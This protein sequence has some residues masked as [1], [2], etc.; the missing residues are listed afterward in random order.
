M[1]SACSE[2]QAMVA[3]FFRSQFRALLQVSRKQYNS[4]LNA[5]FWS[6]GAFYISMF[7]LK[8]ITRYKIV[9]HISRLISNYQRTILQYSN[10]WGHITHSPLMV[11]TRHKS[12]TNT[13]KSAGSNHG[14]SIMSQAIPMWGNSTDPES[15]EVPARFLGTAPSLIVIKGLIWDQLY[16]V[17]V[18]RNKRKNK[19][20]RKREERKKWK[21]VN[22]RGAGSS[23][24][25]LWSWNS[26]SMGPI[27]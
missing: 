2:K 13:K 17:R 10:S 26:Q 5:C 21:G 12:V 27:S 15:W 19:T 22:W 20:E 18:S 16:C 23:W 1:C 14:P 7:L 4:L 11:A 25:S 6:L 9:S 3:C 24:D 8:N